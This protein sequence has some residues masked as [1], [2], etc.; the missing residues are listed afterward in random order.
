MRSDNP[1]DLPVQETWQSLLH[2]RLNLNLSK[3]PWDQKDNLRKS[4]VTRD[5][6]VRFYERLLNDYQAEELVHL[7]RQTRLH[8]VEYQH[9]ETQKSLAEFAERAFKAE[10]RLE[11]LMKLIHVATSRKD[12]ESPL[13]GFQIN[14]W[15]EVSEEGF[16]IG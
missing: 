10:G 4:N 11:A 13:I 14:D 12:P 3:F 8:H 15:G 6:I 7:E 16:E 5:E 9:E 1:S 2:K